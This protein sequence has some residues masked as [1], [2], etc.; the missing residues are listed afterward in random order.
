MKSGIAVAPESP[1]L[2]PV[3]PLVET[4]PCSETEWGRVGAAARQERADPAER[5]GSGRGR[6]FLCPQTGLLAPEMGTG[7]ISTLPTDPSVHPRE[8][9]HHCPW[10]PTHQEMESESLSMP[11]S[12]LAPKGRDFHGSHSEA[13]LGDSMAGLGAENKPVPPYPQP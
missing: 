6:A 1:S 9:P 11:G 10:P 8:L 12:H 4:A 3:D 2:L 7:F 5:R 13:N